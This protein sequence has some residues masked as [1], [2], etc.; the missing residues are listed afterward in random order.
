MIYVFHVFTYVWRECNMSR[1]VQL[2][3]HSQ[4]EFQ[5]L[6]YLVFLPLNSYKFDVRKRIHH[7]FAQK[8]NLVSLIVENQNSNS[9]KHIEIADF[10]LLVILIMPSYQNHH[11][12]FISP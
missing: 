8:S 4:D 10:L 6:I 2:F 5:S 11:R 3:H 7:D 9:L 1:N 12:S